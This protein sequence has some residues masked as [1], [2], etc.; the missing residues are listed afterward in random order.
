MYVDGDEAGRVAQRDDI[1]E[2][3]RTTWLIDAILK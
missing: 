2:V 3:M 1:G